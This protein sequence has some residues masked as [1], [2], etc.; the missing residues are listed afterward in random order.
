MTKSVVR[1][2]TKF[3]G[4]EVHITPV[5]PRY[6]KA[7]LDKAQELYPPP[8]TESFMKPYEQN[9]DALP[10]AMEGETHYLDKTNPEYIRLLTQAAELRNEYIVQTLVSTNCTFLPDTATLISE[11]A[12][13]VKRLREVSDDVP[14]D[15]WEATLWWV[16][17]TREDDRTIVNHLL[18]R[19]PLTE[20]E[21]S[22]ELRF[23]R[24]D[25]QRQKRS[26]VDSD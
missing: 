12:D 2:E 15:E 9:E 5:S 13:D 14:E 1:Y 11:F 23:F 3:T 19:L 4:V 7:V 17:L 6:Y 22:D 26:R 18:D 25:V 21:I 16:I 10:L 24:V 20:D 8:D